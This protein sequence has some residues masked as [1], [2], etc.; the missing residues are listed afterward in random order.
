[1]DHLHSKILIIAFIYAYIYPFL[2]SHP[3]YLF[4]KNRSVPNM[5]QHAIPF[6]TAH[7]L[8]ALTPNPAYITPSHTTHK[9]SQLCPTPPTPSFAHTAPLSGRVTSARVAYKCA[10]WSFS[11]FSI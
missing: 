6:P 5:P 8:S 9:L 3:Y 4:Y 2:I 7:W 11:F 10:V 1:M